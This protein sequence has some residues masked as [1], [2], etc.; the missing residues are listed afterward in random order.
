MVGGREKRL[1][2]REGLAELSLNSVRSSSNKLFGTNAG[3]LPTTAQ[4]ID[5]ELSTSVE[6]G[7]SRMQGWEED[8]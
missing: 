8:F 2:H 3:E 7:E 5:E 4:C 1:A 6:E